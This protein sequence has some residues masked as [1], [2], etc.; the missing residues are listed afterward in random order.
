MNFLPDY[1]D[2]DKSYMEKVISFFRELRITSFYPLA[3]RKS[4]I[5]GEIPVDVP[6]RRQVFFDEFS[7]N[8]PQSPLH[9]GFFYVIT[10]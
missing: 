1:F 6:V 5:F 4:S 3:D 2:S 7:D 10:G 9:V 8:S